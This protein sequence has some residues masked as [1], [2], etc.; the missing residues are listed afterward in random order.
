M[1]TNIQAQSS[2]SNYDN[3]LTHALQKDPVEDH[4]I[5]DQEM[6]EHAASGDGWLNYSAMS[7]PSGSVA[8]KPTAG[9]AEEFV[10]NLSKDHYLN[11]Y[12]QTTSRVPLKGKASKLR[13]GRKSRTLRDWKHD[14]LLAS[15]NAI[16]KGENKAW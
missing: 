10:L 16:S 4:T 2:D 1:A 11:S 5:R 6:I 12:L 3:D 15:G 7:D 13:R 9:H 8:P 14:E